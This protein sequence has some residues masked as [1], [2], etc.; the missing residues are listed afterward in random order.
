MC[1]AIVD[2]TSWS[3]PLDVLVDTGSL[4]VDQFLTFRINQLSSAFERQWSRS[5]R[6]EAGVSLSEWR[7]LAMLQ[8]GSQ[9]FARLVELTEVNKAL[10]HRSAKALSEAEL[11]DISDTPSDARST[12]LSLTDKGRRLLKKI[13][14]LAI[15]R[16]KHFL[17]ALSSDERRT[18]YVALE[19]LRT[20]SN[21]WNATSQE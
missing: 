6:D 7:L 19:K 20:A 2:N 3:D 21:Q 8:S 10:L 13:R 17:S 15:A 14:P 5:M 4:P 16:Q 18:L 9:T 11:I 1:A 12:T